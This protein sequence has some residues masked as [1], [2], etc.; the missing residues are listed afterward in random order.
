MDITVVAADIRLT[1]YKSKVL[2]VPKQIEKI[3]RVKQVKNHTSSK[4]VF[5]ITVKKNLVKKIKILIFKT[6]LTKIVTGIGIAS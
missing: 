3:E 1:L 4:T 2:N 5:I 6:P